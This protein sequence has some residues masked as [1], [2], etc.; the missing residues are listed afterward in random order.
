MGEHGSC[1]VPLQMG[2]P[3]EPWLSRAGA[4]FWDCIWICR[5]QACYQECKWIWLP[6]GPWACSCQIRG[7]VLPIWVPGCTELPLDYGRV[8][9]KPG[10]RAD[11]L[12]AV[13][14]KVNGSLTKGTNRCGSSMVLWWLGLVAV[15][16]TGRVKAEFTE[17]QDYFLAGPRTA[18]RASD[19]IHGSR[20]AL[21]NRPSAVLGSNGISQPPTSIPR[22]PQMQ[23]YS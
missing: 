21:S 2:P 8:R 19:L 20:P 11:S 22:F 3:A 12:V 4:W 1:W 7:W 18:S 14:F 15:L 5:S 23:F 9:L 6:P 13:R 17:G 16:W 10:H